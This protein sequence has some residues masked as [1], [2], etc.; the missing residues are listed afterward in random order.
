MVLL[1][2]SWQVPI[3]EAYCK[4]EN[5]IRFLLISLPAFTAGRESHGYTGKIQD[6]LKSEIVHAFFI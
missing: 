1:P 4:Y 3:P 5:N 2:Y 6:L